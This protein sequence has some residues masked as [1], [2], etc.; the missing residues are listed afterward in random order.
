VIEWDAP[1]A[2]ASTDSDEA[3]SLEDWADWLAQ[4]IHALD[5]A[6]VQVACLSWGGGLALAFAQRHLS[7]VS[8]LLLTSAYAGLGA[9]H[10]P[11]TRCSVISG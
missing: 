6:A 3:A 7:L 4:F 9:G 5:V 1:G 2:G 10:N 8:S 11:T